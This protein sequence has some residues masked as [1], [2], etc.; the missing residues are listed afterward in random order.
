MKSKHLKLKRFILIFLF[1]NLFFFNTDSARALEFSFKPRAGDKYRV[2]STVNEDVFVDY[3]LRYRAEIIN[4]IAFEVTAVNGDK[5]RLSAIIQ[6]AEKSHSV[7]TD[8]KNAPS[9]AFQWEKDYQFELDQDKLGFMTVAEQYYMPMVRNVPVF[10][11]RNLNPGDTWIAQGLEVHDFRDSYG[12]DKPYRIPFTA[13]YTYLGEREWKG[14]S[15]PAFSVSYRILTEPD[16][17]KGKTFPRRILGASDQIVYWDADRGQAAAYEEHFR[18]VFDLSDGQTWEYRGKAEAEV[19]E[20]PPMN[21]EELAKEIA[22]EVAKIPDASV[23]VSDEGIVISLENIQFAPDSARLLPGE[24]PKL[25]KIAEILLKYPERDIL[26]GGHTALAGTAAGRLQL[27]QERAAAVAE[28]LI[29]K[30]VR[31]SERVVIR[32]YG[33]E[34]PVADN[35]TQAGM[36]KNRRVEIT[37]LEN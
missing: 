35:G 1:S 5:A 9:K 23:R 22:E 15:F 27:S 3:K 12:I 14:N 7:G 8:V 11:D 37:I 24:M 20:A 36:Q 6:A 33:A 4:R 21:K 19:I 30:K 10:P 32:G 18:M 29:N 28:Y 16:P 13:N 31:Q 26:V 2:V 17:V 34:Q 25:D